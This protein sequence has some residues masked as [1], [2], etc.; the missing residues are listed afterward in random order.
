MVQQENVAKQKLRVPE[1]IEQPNGFIP[2][3][4]TGYKRPG[5]VLFR[6]GQYISLTMTE[7]MELIQS[8]ILK[9][10]ARKLRSHFSGGTSVFLN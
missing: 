1:E 5:L 8:S 3:M 6:I 7:A 10:H 9:V 2:L 4:I